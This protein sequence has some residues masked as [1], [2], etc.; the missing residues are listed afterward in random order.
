MKKKLLISL[1]AVVLVLSVSIAC[2]AA[3]NKNKN[4]NNNTPAREKTEQDI[5]D[6]ALSD[7]ASALN[8]AKSKLD[9]NERYAYMALAE[10]KLLEATVYVPTTSRGGT[11]ALTRLAPYSVS[12]V[13]FGTDSDR[14]HNAIVAEEIIKPADRTA[15]QGLYAANK[16]T[17]GAYATAAKAYLA[18]H[19]YTV[20]NDYKYPYTSDP[21]TWDITDTQ[22][23]VDSRAIVQTYDGLMEYNAEGALAPALATSYEMSEDGLTYTFHIRSNVKWVTKDGVVYGNV[24][25][26]DWVYGLKRIL[27][28]KKTSGLVYGIIK[29]AKEYANAEIDNFLQVGVSAPDANTLVYT[30]EAPC[31][32][33]VTMLSYNPFAPVNETYATT[34][35]NY[36]TAPDK[37]LY[38]GPYIVS[39]AQENNHITFV[40]NAN[41]WNPS[42][43]QVDT[44]N[45]VSYNNNKDNTRTYTDFLAGTI[46]GVNLN[47][48]TLALAKA[49][50]LGS[51]PDFI[52][53][54]YV[55]TTLTDS[56]AFGVFF[57]LNRQAY[58]TE[59]F[60]D[61][62]SSHTDAQK[63]LA[64]AALNNTNF[65][66]AFGRAFDRAAYNAIE[67]GA[68]LK[69]TNLQN[70][71]TPGTFVQLTAAVTLSI[72][73]QNRTFPVGTQYG[74]IVQ[75][76]INADLGADAP[77]VWDPQADGG[78]G[79]SGGYDGW[80]N[81]TVAKKYLAA[82]IE[83][84][85]A[86]G[87]TVS[88][89]N[90][91]HID[92]PAWTADEIYDARARAFKQNIETV[93]EGKVVIDIV[94]CQSQD[95]WTGCGYDQD[96]GKDMN[97]DIYDVSG[98]GPDYGDP[99]TYLDCIKAVDGD[100]IKMLGLW[101]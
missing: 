100:M 97:Y 80:Y 36:G 96:Y 63:A 79:S 72:N 93:L 22:R 48:A 66:R 16:G 25:A 85:A 68:D 92:Y 41:Y 88:A 74:E 31:S 30:L 9:V 64:N 61:V 90:P 82:A 5:Y 8:T 37:I 91:I 35:A 46:D 89:E 18:S 65:R 15:L 27:T 58:S 38:C 77:K 75:A 95:S 13:L 26:N 76:Q 39:D 71:F 47:T 78:I 11:Y 28:N 101:A 24:T 12:P 34:T 32:Y 53:N 7:F 44:L 10:A 59:G 56:T 50:K 40:K 42:A 87:Y 14:L 55:F 54:T 19:G 1:I 20:R 2:F 70:M 81:P 51:D 23:Q 67:R 52:F 43:V 29:N 60:D 3:C 62:T 57:N 45:W 84:L 33:F 6:G 21:A 73:G 83:E 86:Q 94:E 98:W 99:A 17:P 4:N 69:L 49:N